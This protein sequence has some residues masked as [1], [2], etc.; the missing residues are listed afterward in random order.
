M[1]CAP[2]V[3]LMM[4][5]RPKMIARPR[6]QHRVEG[7]VDQAEQQA[8]RTGPAA[9]F[10]GA[11]TC[12]AILVR[13]ASESE[14]GRGHGSRAPPMSSASLLDERAAAF[15]RADGTPRPPGSW[16]RSRNSP[17]GPSD[18]SGVLTRKRY[19]SWIL[20]PSARTSPL[21]NSGSSVGISF[22]LA[23]TAVPHPCRRRPRPPSG[24]AAR[25]HRRRPGPCDGFLPVSSSKRADHSRVWSLRSQ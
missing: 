8:G 10:P 24:S 7:A 17:T 20:R 9:E 25:S 21:P 11:R 15:A 14:C 13:E 4:L 12:A 22:I 2:W 23:T 18:W 5:S 16:R 6:L 19:M 3:K 1:Y